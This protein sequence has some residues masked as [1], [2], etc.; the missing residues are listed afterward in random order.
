MPKQ[1]QF[2]KSARQKRLNDFKVK[3]HQQGAT[4]EDDRLTDFLV[5][6]FALTAKKRVPTRMQETCQRFL[7]E[8]SDR[9]VAGNGDLQLLVPGLVEKLSSQ[10]PWQF[11]F[12]L[13]TNW[14]LLQEFLV[15]E[16]PAVPLKYHLRIVEQVTAEE[17]SQQVAHQLAL[18]GAATTLLNQGASK[19]KLNQV[20]TLLQATICPKS[21]IDWERVRALLSPLPFTPD[22]QLD[23]P[24]K[25]WLTGLSQ[26]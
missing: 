22:P 25:K 13:V 23:Q 18:K 1:G 17:L 5:V 10:V 11:F 6:R 26:L 7:I 21:A 2:A 24:T 19:K 14:D 15:K 4:I 12:Q 8:I 20:A 16:L 9:L 3:R